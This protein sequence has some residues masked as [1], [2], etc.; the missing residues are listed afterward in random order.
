MLSNLQK[1]MDDQQMKM[2]RLRETAALEKDTATR[3]QTTTQTSRH[4]A[5]VAV[6]PLRRRKSSG[7]SVTTAR[8]GIRA[9]HRQLKARLV[10]D[11]QR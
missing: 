5:E 10:G 1:Q 8:R 7:F 3:I 4:A 11:S 6:F 2:I 9:F